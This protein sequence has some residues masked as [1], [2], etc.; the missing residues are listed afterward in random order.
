MIVTSNGRGRDARSKSPSAT[1]PESATLIKNKVRCRQRL[2]QATVAIVPSMR[3]ANPYRDPTASVERASVSSQ[4]T[5]S[6][7]TASVIAASNRSSGAG[8]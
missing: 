5:R 6:A 7:T 2:N 8:S 4:P 1:T 3:I